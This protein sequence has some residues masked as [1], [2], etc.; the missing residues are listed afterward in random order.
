MHRDLIGDQVQEYYFTIWLVWS[1]AM[2]LVIIIDNIS[3]Q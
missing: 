3:D 2:L 1:L